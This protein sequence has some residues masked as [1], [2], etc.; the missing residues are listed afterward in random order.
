V[1]A[2]DGGEVQTRLSEVGGDEVI[3]Q[4]QQI[5]SEIQK[6]GG[7]ASTASLGAAATGI[8]AVGEAAFQVAGKI[9]DF[10]GGLVDMTA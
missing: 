3:A 10:I 6:I 9:S 4:L 1:G 8:V 2:V 7:S 5:Q